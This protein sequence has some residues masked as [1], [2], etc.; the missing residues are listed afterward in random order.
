M[1]QIKLCIIVILIVCVLFISPDNCKAIGEETKVDGKVKPM[2]GGPGGSESTSGETTISL[3]I[4]SNPT[5]ASVFIDTVFKGYTPLVIPSIPCRLHNFTFAKD[6][7]K[8]KSFLY[9]L[10]DSMKQLN[11]NLELVHTN[12]TSSKKQVNVTV[13]NQ[14]E[15]AASEIRAEQPTKVEN[16]T[17]PSNP[18]ISWPQP[19]AQWILIFLAFISFIIGP[20]ILRDIV[21][22][23]K[24]KMQEKKKK[25][26]DGKALLSANLEEQNE[27][28]AIIKVTNVGVAIAKNYCILF[29]GKTSTGEHYDKK[30]PDQTGYS[31]PAQ[32]STSI[33]IECNNWIEICVEMRWDDDSGSD[34]IVKMCFQLTPI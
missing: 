12:E 30:V 17:K 1:R 25:S 16:A 31:I 5:K 13:L 2:A 8:S 21:K 20:G 33:P 23:K 14:S 26:D 3:T 15:K 7:Y 22:Y 28:Y 34:N 19:S 10:N 29:S 4:N 24:N 18:E 27:G 6:G 11:E 32:H 9:V